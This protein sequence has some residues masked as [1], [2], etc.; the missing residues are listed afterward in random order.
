MV[1]NEQL[2]VTTDILQNATDSTAT[3]NDSLPPSITVSNLLYRKNDYL[4]TYISFP[5]PKG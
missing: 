3:I 2:A 5:I 1:Q 4:L